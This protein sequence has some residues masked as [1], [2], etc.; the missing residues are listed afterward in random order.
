MTTMTNPGRPR[1]APKRRRSKVIRRVVI[2]LL[3]LIG[4]LV[5]AD[6]GA[7]AIAEHEVSKRARTQFGLDDDPSVT[8]HGF[9]FL[10]QAVS[11]EYDDV[12]VKATGVP[13]K[14]ALRDV[15]VHVDLR[16]AKAPLGDL[17]SGDTK[18]IQVR[19]ADGQVT[20]KASDVTRA[21]SQNENEVVKTLTS[22]S[23]NPVSK[24][25]ATT[26]NSAD[27]V[28][29][30]PGTLKDP[31]TAGAKICGTA[32]IGGTSTNLCVYGLITLANQKINFQP[33][34][35]KVTNGLTSG[36]LPSALRDRVL[37]P[38]GAISLDPGVLPF[39][40]TP[41]AVEVKADKLI[42]SGTAE[43]VQLGGTA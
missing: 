1:T 33:W 34:W 5:A 11:G 12:E 38:F 15:E 37:A 22:V 4:L 13:V 41:T 35:P 31:T 29:D 3:V 23:I 8:I 16:G 30:P 18:G 27:D 2:G 21:I 40:V 19:K 14:N 39:K 17:L 6:F 10:L 26:P 7:A 43:N 42:V 9:S 28:E 20:V 36:G 25:A 32:D 24:K